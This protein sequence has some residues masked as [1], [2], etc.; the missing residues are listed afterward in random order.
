M[1]DQEQ[2]KAAASAPVPTL[3]SKDERTMGMLC[4]LLGL[5]G[6]VGPLI[7]WLIKKEEMP[8]VNDQGREALNFQLT[9]LIGWAVIVVLAFVTCGAGAALAPVLM[10]VN[11]IFAIMG[12]LKA[13]D[14]VPYR[15]P[16]NLRLIK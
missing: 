3:L 15:Y 6:F 11:V 9:L 7:I 14:G 1:P 2:P 16:V 10:I 8:F 4:H 13:N 12:A 5:V